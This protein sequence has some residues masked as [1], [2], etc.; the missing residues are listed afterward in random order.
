M[1]CAAQNKQ[2]A[3]GVARLA[4]AQAPDGLVDEEAQPR[5]PLRQRTR[6]II[7]RPPSPLPE[8]VHDTR[9]MLQLEALCVN[10]WSHAHA[11]PCLPF[12][13]LTKSGMCHLP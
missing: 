5:G 11:N 12:M 8:S 10:P 2:S 6:H 13:L 4:D 7:L 9:K 3:P 1:A